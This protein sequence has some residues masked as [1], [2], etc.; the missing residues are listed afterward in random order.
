MLDPKFKSFHLMSSFIGYEQK[1]AIVQEY[2][3][4]FLYPM[5]LKCYHDLHLMIKSES[6]FANQTMDVD[7]DLDIF[8]MVT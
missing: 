1:V 5:L 4:R 8:G 2:D 6:E 7:C 3:E